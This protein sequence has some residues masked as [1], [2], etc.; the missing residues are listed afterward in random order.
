MKY[1]NNNTNGEW[2]LNSTYS[3]YLNSRHLLALVIYAGTD[4]LVSLV[5]WTLAWLIVYGQEEACPPP[6]LPLNI[7]L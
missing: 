4:F 7:I 6:P 5:V 1:Y 2:R 3:Q